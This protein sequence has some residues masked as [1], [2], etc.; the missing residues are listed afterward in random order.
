MTN[1]ILIFIALTLCS[2]YAEL[3]KINDRKDK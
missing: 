3:K 1:I 2:I